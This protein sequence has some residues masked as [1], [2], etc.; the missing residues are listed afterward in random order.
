VD[1]EIVLS[2][3]KKQAWRKFLAAIASG[4]RNWLIACMIII[5]VLV[6]V[7]VIGKLPVE[8]LNVLWWILIIAVFMIVILW[9]I[10]RHSKN[11]EIENEEKTRFKTSYTKPGD[12][13]QIG[14]TYEF[15]KKDEK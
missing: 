14:R 10:Y 13:P 15:K 7:L 3:D 6:I 4:G 5:V 12:E 9:I 11:K 1:K 8:I 2:R